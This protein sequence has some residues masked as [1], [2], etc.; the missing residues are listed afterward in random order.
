MSWLNLLIAR[1]ADLDDDDFIKNGVAKNV[2]I[3]E[4]MVGMTKRQLYDNLK[5]AYGEKYFNSEF[6][7]KEQ[8]RLT[9]ATI[10]G[11]CSCCPFCFA[12]IEKSQGCNH[13]FCTNCKR[14][15]NYMDPKNPK[16]MFLK[17]RTDE[18]KEVV[19]NLKV[20]DRTFNY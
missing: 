3:P 18:E 16:A 2:S 20:D 5:A 11:T 19:K 1:L 13:M 6:L 14:T 9:L 12:P 15:F 10:N 4:T 7:V 17:D 8:E